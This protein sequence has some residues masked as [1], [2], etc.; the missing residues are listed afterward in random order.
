[1][2]PES[3]ECPE[4]GPSQEHPGEPDPPCRACFSLTLL[5]VLTCDPSIFSFFQFIQLFL[6]YQQFSILPMLS[7]FFFIKIGIATEL[8]ILH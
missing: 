6:A 4:L 5:F 3:K 8:T 7:S 1:M 2:A